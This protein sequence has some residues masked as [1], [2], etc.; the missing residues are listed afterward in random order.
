MRFGFSH[1]S[2]TSDKVT[3]PFNSPS[4]TLSI[5][6]ISDYYQLSAIHQV[7]AKMR[8]LYLV[9]LSIP[10]LYAAELS[11][12][13]VPSAPQLINHETNNL[14]FAPGRY[15]LQSK[16]RGPR[17]FK[18]PKYVTYRKSILKWRNRGA[19]AGGAIAGHRYAA[20]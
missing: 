12:N 19:M 10:A 1:Q 3:H 4:I 5:T 18:S 15:I 2:D 14:Y 17:A 6:H 20:G 7:A 9:L 13:A 8:I 16:Q 11:Q